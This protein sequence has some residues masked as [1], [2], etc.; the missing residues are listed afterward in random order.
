M[1]EVG[2]PERAGQ[3]V[4]PDVQLSGQEESRLRGLLC[5]NGVSGAWG[6]SGIPSHPFCIHNLQYFPIFKAYCLLSISIFC[7]AE[8]ILVLIMEGHTRHTGS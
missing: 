6:S 7:K 5:I 8:Y 2:L 3:L 1:G 4:D